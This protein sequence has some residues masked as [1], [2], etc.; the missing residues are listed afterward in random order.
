MKQWKLKPNCSMSLIYDTF[1]IC[2]YSVQL[3]RE[4]IDEISNSDDENQRR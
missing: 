1:F 3:L 2:S 4:T